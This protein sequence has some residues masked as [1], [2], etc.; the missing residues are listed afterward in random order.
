MVMVIIGSLGTYD[1]V[2][3]YQYFDCNTHGFGDMLG[4]I[5]LVRWKSD[6]MVKCKCISKFSR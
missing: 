6:G 3:L 2:S 5:E 4:L 1:V